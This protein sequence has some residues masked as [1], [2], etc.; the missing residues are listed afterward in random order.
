MAGKTAILA[1]VCGAFVLFGLIAAADSI[2][3]TRRGLQSQ[4]WPT[5]E[6]EILRAQKRRGKSRLKRFEYRYTVSGQEYLSSR[7]A[8]IRTPYLRPLHRVY[9]SGQA[10]DV[11]YNPDDPAEAVVEPGAPL[12]GLLA[13]AL[14]PLLLI[15]FGGAGFYFGAVRR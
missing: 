7:A 6:G 3:D 9:S 14:V 12:L 15:G 2:G 10:V 13:E 5:A 4:A 11:R 1:A 8:F